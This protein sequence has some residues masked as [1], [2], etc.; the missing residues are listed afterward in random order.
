MVCVNWESVGGG[1]FLRERRDD[2]KIFEWSE[3]F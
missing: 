2:C 3:L 1:G